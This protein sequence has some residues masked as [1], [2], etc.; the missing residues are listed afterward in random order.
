MPADRFRQ[1]VEPT[2]CP[3]YGCVRTNGDTSLPQHQ[4][5]LQMTLMSKAIPTMRSPTAEPNTS[6]KSTLK[7]RLEE[8]RGD[9]VPKAVALQLLA[10][11]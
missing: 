7:I 11:D 9:S 3:G 10:A 1:Q 6:C 8:V 4:E 5:L 2:K